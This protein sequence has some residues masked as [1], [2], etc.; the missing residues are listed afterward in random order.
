MYSR[1]QAAGGPGS[2]SEATLFRQAQAGCRDSL[3]L[4]MARHE[5]LVQAVVRRY[6]FGELAF[7]EAVHLGR[8]GLWRAVLHYTPERGWAFSTYAWPCIR[9]GDS[10]RGADP[11]PAEGSAHRLMDSP[12]GSGSG[13][14][15]GAGNPGG[16][17]GPTATGGTPPRALAL[18]DRGV[19]WV[20]Q[21]NRPPPTRR[22]AHIW[23]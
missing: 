23:G 2:T 15:P 8:M 13:R 12:L 17:T 10:G 5:G 21:A 16:S 20:S 22:S 3:N 4:L 19:L 1:R 18:C 14:P 6:G 9:N 7:T 11:R